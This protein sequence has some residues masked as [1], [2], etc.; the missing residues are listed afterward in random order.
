MGF[1]SSL[2]GKAST[3]NA[4]DP[5]SIPGS[6]RSPGEGIRLPTPVFSF[7]GGSDGRVHLQCR[8]PGFDSWVSKIPRRRAWQPT[9]VFLSGESPWTGEPGG[10]QSM[11]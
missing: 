8:R 6:G 4:G 2:A 10:L 9:A 5:G 11:G 7:S 1:P 3:C